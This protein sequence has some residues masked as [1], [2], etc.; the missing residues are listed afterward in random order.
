MSAP[1]KP[2]YANLEVLHRNRLPTR[3]YWIP[4]TSTLLNG[5]W[6][7]HYALSPLEAPEVGKSSSQLHLDETW[8][9][10]NVPGHWQLQGHGRPHYTNVIY[11]FPVCPPEI[12]TENPTGTYRRAF[13]VPPAWDSSSQLRLRFEGVDSSYHVWV[14]GEFAGYSQGSRNAA[15]FDVGSLVD[16]SS[17]NE[18][19][20][21]VYQWCEGS[22]IE[23]QDQWWLSGIF[24]DVYL[25]AF[26]ADA[27]IED[28]FIKTD[29]DNNYCDATLLVEAT[30]SSPADSRLTLTLRD[31][32]E[33]IA[34]VADTLDSGS[35]TCKLEIP[36]KNPKKWTAETPFL[37]ELTLVLSKDSKVVQTIV[38][39]VGFRKVE[40]KNGLITVNGKPLLL[41]GANRHDHH[42]RFG[43]SVP[44]DFM[45]D[46]LLL[47]KQHNINALR[48]SH[49]PAHPRLYDIADELGLWVMDEADL[50]CHG[51]Y[52]AV[53]RPLDIP[54]EM[55]Y[56][57]RK[58][59]TFPQAA[60][61]TS[62]NP[63]WKE[64]YVD[65][66]RQLIQRDKNHASVVM[67]SLGNEAFYGC[68]HAA[69]YDYAKSVDP[70]RPVHYEGDVKAVSTDMYSYM[71][72]S[73]ERLSKWVETEGV[74][75]DG[76]FSKPV[77]LCEYA[78][79][80]GNGPGWLEDYQNMFR[81]Y[82]R[83]QGG[84]I[85]EWANHGLWHPQGG[86]YGYGGDFGDE[87]NDATFVM[88]GLCNS[89]H[90]PTPGLLELKKV[91]QPVKFELED[92]KLFVTNEYDFVDLNHLSATYRIET[93]GNRNSSALLA[94]G[95]LEI[96]QVKPW[97]RAQLQ[98][99]P[100]LGKYKDTPGEIYLTVRFA[101]RSGV[102]WASDFHEIAWWQSKIFDGP[103]APSVAVGPMTGAITAEDTRATLNLSGADWT[104]TLDK[105]RGYVVGWTHAGQALVE[106]DSNTRAAIIPAFWRAPTDND[107]PGDI[108][109]PGSLPYWKHYGV[110]ALTSQLRQF[111]WKKHEATGS[112]E[113][114]VHSYL[115]PP[116]LGWGYRV[117]ITYTIS[118]AGSLSIQVK[119]HPEGPIPENIPRLGLNIRLPKRLS[120]T[121]WFGLGPGESYPDKKSAQRIGI[122]TKT[123]E[124]LEYPYDVPQENGNRMDTRW[125]MVG[126]AYCA[127]VEATMLSGSGTFSWNAGRYSAKEL[128]NAKHPC[129]LVA[130]DATLLCLSSKVAGVGTAACGPG[131]RDDLQV[132]VED[133][134]FEFFLQPTAS[135]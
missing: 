135:R 18:L 82:P 46:D 67:W 20:V 97:S 22:Y 45:R 80:M 19:V 10:I 72:P 130:E 24:R 88:D 59:L 73:M 101:L 57:E 104:L 21:Q 6:D 49:Y 109:I 37:Y 131:V 56:E 128:E 65:R 50:E 122:W 33:K 43:R 124:E 63:A 116:I 79:A 13:T 68:N 36:V 119:V 132:K 94:S 114:N 42:P 134:E 112:V 66:M 14:N 8:T 115:S 87:P 95:D 117:A 12:P 123:V 58:A 108:D 120:H 127:G 32:S 77:V 64:A 60:K 44:L 76:T 61:F 4:E 89:E 53:A 47:M 121:K 126:D 96:P 48:T 51:F 100:E 92:G 7:F 40:I 75:D 118:L 9:H 85:W 106:I 111:T 11:P 102:N 71:Y 31:G 3:A 74:K 25:I 38:Q 81:K 1:D 133:D 28:F 105:V 15:E 2:D 110:D 69:M 27:R 107:R 113:V 52:D 93:F 54:E 41:R 16:R 125:L 90:K 129:D 62:D 34:S 17:S 103:K 29:L 5:E 55:D 70:E 26:P 84:F 86:F 98:L 99:P 78:H 30:L 39:R 91:F 83:L 35:P 23:D